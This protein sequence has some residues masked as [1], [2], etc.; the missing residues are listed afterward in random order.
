MNDIP[1]FRTFLLALQGRQPF[2]WQERAALELAESGWWQSLSAPTGAGKTTLM[3]A[4]LWA[5]ARSG[6]GRLGR[7]MFW[8]VDRR[9]V[10]D[11]VYAH[12]TRV[13]TQL[14]TGAHPDADAA[15]RA[16]WLRL[17]QI[18]GGGTSGGDDSPRAAL[19]RGG[20]DDA[21]RSEAAALLDAARVTVV[22]ST[23]DQV[24]SRLL[25]RGY[26][27]RRGSRSAH[28]GL[29]GTD[30][31]IVIDEAHIARPFTCSLAHVQDIQKSAGDQP[32]SPTRSITITATPRGASD[33]TLTDQELADPAIARRL[34]AAKR[35]TLQE[36]T[37]PA[38]VVRTA[39][40]LA[41][42]RP[43]AT[44]GIVLNTVSQARAVFDTLAAVD[45]DRTLLIGPVRPLDRAANLAMVP[46]RD[47]RSGRKRPTYVVATQTIEV[48]VDLDFDA[49]ITACAP[50]PSLIQRLGRLDR[51]G[52]LGASSAVV[53]APPK[54]TC[55]V[56]GDD[57]RDAW[58]WLLECG[59]GGADGLD[60]GPTAVARLGATVPWPN[61]KGD[62][63]VRAPVL[64]PL[65]I[66]ALS[67]ID[68]DDTESPDIDLFLHGIREITPEVSVVWRGDISDGMAL[69]EVRRRVGLRPPH[70][71]EALSLSRAALSRWL[72]GETPATLADVPLEDE[73]TEQ[74]NSRHTIRP[75]RTAWLVQQRGFGRLE[76]GPVEP[77]RMLPGA[78][79][80]LAA[81]SGGC[82]EF[83]WA[84]TSQ[85]PPSDLGS[86]GAARPRCVLHTEDPLAAT[87]LASLLEDHEAGCL[88]LSDLAQ[89]SRRMMR[90]GLPG[91]ERYAEQRARVEELIVNGTIEVLPDGLGLLAIGAVPESRRRTG[92]RH[93]TTL[94]DHQEAVA[95]Y[96][97]NM[98]LALGLDPG[99]TAD[100]LLAARHHDDGKRDARFQSWL[101]G[102]TPSDEDLAKS[103]YG[104]S[105]ARIA[106]LREA[107]GWPEGKR[108]EVTSAEII[109]CGAP[110]RDLAAWLALTHHG[111]NRPYIRR[112][113]DTEGASLEI[114]VTVDGQHTTVAGDA[115]PDPAWAF[116]SLDRLTRR[117]GP[118]GL[119]LLEAIL[120]T[121]DHTASREPD[122]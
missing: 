61:P 91:A 97:E 29:V 43:G 89:E 87:G 115:C 14:N 98:A 90:A 2:D 111:R 45:G 57:T 80:V 78:T 107:S 59:A 55:P 63:A 12:A 101:S 105:P 75:A 33:F 120:I 81:S 85:T 56:Y 82:D 93:I 20:L 71:G 41:E 15:I 65:H 26:G 5:L 76:V 122:R 108:H 46:T 54:K 1:S 84:P 69:E 62:D 92:A 99:I 64:L 37:T 77:W 16:V 117:H 112:V 121:A 48:G 28:A 39:R 104:W 96:A 42:V 35:V 47:E 66:D 60:M 23:I 49:L 100:V 40:Q 79:V 7:R 88:D 22:C 83:G 118:W 19:W 72:Q 86:L 36:K 21:T 68:G 110:G 70:S 24:G 113:P 74:A 30:S 38:D 102:G 8:V 6:P 13:V 50:V 94:V 25:F 73:D 9:A 103:T 51:I 44:V 109:R 4:W 53:L 106:R 18:G 114:T 31:I 52:H 58:D 119:A 10:V 95:Q 17:T 116:Q 27:T 34:N 3:E 32:L 67:W 11:Q